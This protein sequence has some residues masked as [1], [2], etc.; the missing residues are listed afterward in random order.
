MTPASISEL[1]NRTQSVPTPTGPQ[2]TTIRF[3]AQEIVDHLKSAL[4]SAYTGKDPKK[5]HLTKGEAAFLSLAE[6]AQDGNGEALEQLLNRLLGKPIQQVNSLN[7]SASLSEFLGS[8][9]G[10]L[11]KNEP[12]DAEVDPF[13]D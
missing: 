6:Q 1:T 5:Q 10:E 4:T 7:V 2:S 8:L 12:L 9:A 13:S 3:T 11:D